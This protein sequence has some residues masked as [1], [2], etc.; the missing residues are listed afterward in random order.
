M[1]FRAADDVLAGMPAAKRNRT[2]F[3]SFTAVGS[4][5]HIA[6]FCTNEIHCSLLNLYECDQSAKKLGWKYFDDSVPGLPIER[7]AS[8]RRA[9]Q[10]EMKIQ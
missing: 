10:N 9:T 7:T 2:T 8:S 5:V 4:H 3:I 1:E 6:S